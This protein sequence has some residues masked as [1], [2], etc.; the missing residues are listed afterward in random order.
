M[1]NNTLTEDLR[2][3]VNETTRRELE[4]IAERDERS[5]AAV[6]RRFIREGL[7]R[8]RDEVRP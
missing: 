7:E 3:R 6:I 8:A 4:D 2:V 5:V 1:T